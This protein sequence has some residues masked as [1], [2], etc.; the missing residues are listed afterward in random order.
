MTDFDGLR[1]AV[2]PGEG[3][4]A[5]FPGVFCVARAADQ[6]AATHLRAL[7]DLCRD[8]AGSAP[9]RLLARRL[10]G[11]LSGLGDSVDRLHFGSV[12]ATGDDGLAVFLVGDA[13]LL[14]PQLGTE[15]S[16]SDAAAWTDRLLPRPEA[17][18]VL[19]LAGVADP[20][21]ATAGM[22]DLR[23]GIVPGAAAVLVHVD[24][25]PVDAV[26]VDAPEGDTALMAVPTPDPFPPQAPQPAPAGAPQA[27]QPVEPIPLPP[28]RRADP[29]L[30][31]ADD[32]QRPPL[33]TGR[34]DEENLHEDTSGAAQEPQAL[35][36]LC[37]RGHLNDPRSHFCVLCGIR[38]NERT[39][40]LVTGPRPPL[41]LLVFDNGAT[42][43]VDA[44]YVIGRQPE[45]DERVRSGALRALAVDDHT[46]S[47]SRVHAEVRLEGWEVLLADA[48]S[49]NGTFLAPPGEDWVQLEPEE[50]RR[51]VPG[52]KA[53][54]GDC[55]FTYESPSGVR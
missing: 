52:T 48:G 50:R 2:V 47:V 12:A 32:A 29:I 8:T 14:I 46:G 54:L 55:L 31:V 51:L 25:V 22:H 37:S 5:R 15:I 35:G 38:M 28:P 44:E 19:T 49:S 21:A 26:P 20:L 13:R 18:V 34:P 1:C 10:A 16:G 36:H 3:V 33:P 27:A 41:G 4:V 53:R 17:P 23:S 45:V 7:V 11:R 43:T 9:G 39:G 30:G 42:Y 24:A 6:R 40:V